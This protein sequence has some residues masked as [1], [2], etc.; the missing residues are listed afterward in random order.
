MALAQ[1]VQVR[2]PSRSA[3]LYF[4]SPSWW[5]FICISGG[6]LYQVGHVQSRVLLERKQ[7]KARSHT[8]AFMLFWN[9]QE[10]RLEAVTRISGGEKAPAL[11]APK[12][13]SHV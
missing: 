12:T 2:M 3:I 8:N 7:R 1:R 11:S 13:V 5:K 9:P 4:G 6:N 10:Q